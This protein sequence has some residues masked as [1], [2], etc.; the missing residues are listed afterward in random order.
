M[1]SKERFHAT[2]ARQPVD[3]PAVWMSA[4]IGAEQESQVHTIRYVY[5]RDIPVIKFV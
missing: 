5:M 1:T 4:P 3:R 2:I